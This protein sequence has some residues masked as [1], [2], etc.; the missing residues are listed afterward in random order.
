MEVSVRDDTRYLAS[1]KIYIRREGSHF[2]GLCGELQEVVNGVS[3]DDI[4]EKTK[5]LVKRALHQEIPLTISVR[6][7][8]R[9][10]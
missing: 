6:A 10:T 2:V 1:V 8:H 3:V 7:S 4:V 9:N 5:T